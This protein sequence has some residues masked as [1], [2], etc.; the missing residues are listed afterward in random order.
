MNIYQAIPSRHTDRSNEYC[1]TTGGIQ[2]HTFR[3]GR[4]L[5]KFGNFQVDSYIGVNI[6]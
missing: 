6:L 3:M 2:G 4:F 5:K 1:F